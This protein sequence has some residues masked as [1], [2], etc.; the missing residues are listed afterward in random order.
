MLGL[1]DIDQLNEI[2][3]ACVEGSVEKCTEVLNTFL[4]SGVSI[5]RFVFDSANYIR[6]LLFI[7]N[8]ITRKDILGNVSDRYSS[9]V[10]NKWNT[11]QLQRALS[12]FFQLHRDIRYSLSPSY[13]LE[14]TFSRLCWLSEYVS[15]AEVKKAIDAAQNLLMANIPTA[16]KS[17]LKH[18]ALK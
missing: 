12:I 9:K 17:V 13:E 5:E 1:I 2:F 15:N 8:G 6:S 14:L 3:E 11:V 16:S 7:K 10:I 18:H 4:Q